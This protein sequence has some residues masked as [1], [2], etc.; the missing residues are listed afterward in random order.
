MPL[1]RHLYT[2]NRPTHRWCPEEKHK[3]DTSDDRWKRMTFLRSQA[4]HQPFLHWKFL[5]LIRLHRVPSLTVLLVHLGPSNIKRYSTCCE[6]TLFISSR[7]LDTTC[8]CV[9]PLQAW[10]HHSFKVKTSS[11]AKPSLCRR[12]ACLFTGE[13][14]NHRPSPDI[15]TFSLL[16]E[17]TIISVVK[18]WNWTKTYSWPG[19]TSL[20]YA[21]LARTTAR[22]WL[23]VRGEP[24]LLN[25]LTTEA[26]AKTT[27]S[28][29][30]CRNIQHLQKLSE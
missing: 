15:L 25:N 21:W 24:W 6:I 8:H 18:V 1:Q 22:S 23:P 10:P 7:D 4:R 26:R 27:N 5:P 16:P 3:Q 19:L 12:E 11:S 9:G 17:P 30:A 13:K 14:K 2:W 20:G 28:C 29:R